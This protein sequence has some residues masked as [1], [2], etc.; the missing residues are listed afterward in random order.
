MLPSDCLPCFMVREP[1]VNPDVFSWVTFHRENNPVIR[2]E[3]FCCGLMFEKHESSD[4][5]R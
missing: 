5:L 2:D 4:I 1:E 3:I